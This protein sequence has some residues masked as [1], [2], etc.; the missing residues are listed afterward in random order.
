[1]E[2][3]APRIE[4]GDEFFDIPTFMSRN[5]VSRTLVF[6]EIAAGRLRAWKAG[7]RNV[8]PRSEETSPTSA[9]RS[10]LICAT[11]LGRPSRFMPG[12]GGSLTIL[13][14]GFGVPP[15]CS[16]F[17]P[18]WRAARSRRSRNS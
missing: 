4:D 18:R 6:R 2:Q 13:Q 17:R 5:Y 9:I 15:E 11:A 7:G 1:M 16:L 12:A 8:I 14:C 10:T 3:N